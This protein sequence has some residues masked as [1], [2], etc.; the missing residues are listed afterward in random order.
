[1]KWLIYGSKGWIGGLVINYIK[2]NMTEEVIYEGVSRV[3]NEKEVEEE[4][5]SINPD[6]VLSFIGR[7]HGQGYSTIDY[8]EQKGSLLKILKIIYTRQWF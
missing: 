1:M 2:N 5:K 4:L 6:R 7:T 3:D 8:L